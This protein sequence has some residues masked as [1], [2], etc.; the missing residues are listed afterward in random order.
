MTFDSDIQWEAYAGGGLRFDSHRGFVIRLDARVSIIPGAIN[1][2]AAEGDVSV[3]IEFR[4]GKKAPRAT[5]PELEKVADKDADGI[6][7]ASDSCVDRPEDRDGFADDDGCPDI[8][9]DGDQVLDIADRCSQE[10]ETYNGFTDDDGCPDTL[11]PEVDALRGTVEGLLYAE[12]E[13]AV[14][15]S[16][17][18]NLE[19]IAAVMKQHPSIRVMFIGHTDDREAKQFAEV[20]EGQPP[21]DLGPLSED[22]SR[23]RAEAARQALAGLGIP[24][25]RIEIDGRGFEEPVTENDKPKGRLANRRVEIKLYV[26]PR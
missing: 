10:S 16:A 9:N 20:V 15:D 5:G 4:L 26:P 14:R 25:S 24:A 18:R 12:G 2:L 11:P 22:L 23:A 1:Y 3:G 13:T 21:P 6:P 19:K 17:L 8:D 7:D